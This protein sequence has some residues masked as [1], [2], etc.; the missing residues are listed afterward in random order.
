MF[1]KGIGVTLY[2]I[3]VGAVLAI[4]ARPAAGQ[5]P[6]TT[7]PTCGA[8]ACAQQPSCVKAPLCARHCPVAPTSS[9]CVE[10][11]KELEF[12]GTVSKVDG[13][14]LGV[15]DESGVETNV[16]MQ[17][18]TRIKPWKNHGHGVFG[19]TRWFG[20]GSS[21]GTD[22]TALIVGLPVRV[23]GRGNC[24]GQLVAESI[25]Y[26]A[27]CCVCLENRLCAAEAAI[28]KLGDQLAE[29]AALAASAAK[30]SRAALEAAARAQST[31]DQA[32]SIAS[33]NQAT[34][35]AA[36]AR[37]ASLDDFEITDS[38]TVNFKAGSAVLSDEAKS[39]LNEFSA[40]T[41]NA[42]GYIV[43]IA[44]Y[45]SKEGALSYNDA[46]SER[47]ADAVMDYLISQGKVPMRRLTAPY[48]GGIS[49]PIADNSTPE[50]REQNR[51]AEV[52]MLVSKG[53]A[54]TEPVTTQTRED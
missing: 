33:A 37:L 52:K 1:S 35:S 42:K 9:R 11:G 2:V 34:I 6:Q 36:Q 10:N 50:G 8:P 51:R 17:P 54:G 30:D 23:E 22:Q 38:L 26:T 27:D 5:E 16:L 40:K 49:N 28:S 47:R 13:D 18:S 46:L 31:A 32:N 19:R 14:I 15:V 39:K 12:N 7:S 3:L 45:A 4:A 44:G 25:K 29:T 53:L 21:G 43:E 41:A 20:N 48:G 24:A